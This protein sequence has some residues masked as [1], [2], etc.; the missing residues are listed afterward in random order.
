MSKK[1]TTAQAASVTFDATPTS[2]KDAGYKS[3][4]AGETLAQIAAWVYA[5]C[6]DFANE[7]PKEVKAELT[8]GWALRWQE[9]NPAV[10]YN[11]L[12]GY[13]PDE[14]GDIQATLAWCLSYSQQAFGQLK[15]DDP[16]RHGIMGDIRTKFNKY[17][18]N[19]L[20]DLQR[21]VRQ[22]QNAGKP[23]ERVQAKDFVDYMKDTFD[24]MKSRC[25]TAK[26]RSDATAPDE[27]KL[28]MAIDAFY[29]AL[30]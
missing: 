16:V 23:R 20:K 22:L 11:S 10:M 28:R 13:I 9:L 30:K 25:K 14:K 29:A 18:S 2:Y 5:K 4:L 12:K 15:K 19:K 21:A 3:A 27:V 7:V 26:A 24:D 17:A 1:T 8:E 6:P